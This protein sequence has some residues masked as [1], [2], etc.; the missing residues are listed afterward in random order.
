[1]TAESLS[2]CPGV[3]VG[4]AGSQEQRLFVNNVLGASRG[5]KVENL[6]S[7]KGFWE[8]FGGGTVGSSLE[9][10]L[11][12]VVDHRKARRHWHASSA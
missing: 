12:M 9:A 4:D 3:R 5:G 11:R 1:M 10:H 8:L 6:R 2:V 7:L